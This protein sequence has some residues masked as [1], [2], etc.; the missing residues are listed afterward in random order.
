MPQIS[1]VLRTVRQSFNENIGVW[2]DV[3]NAVFD[4]IEEGMEGE[5]HIVTTGG[6]KQLSI[7]A[8]GAEDEAR[9]AVVRVTGAL[10]TNVTVEAPAAD[11]KYFV[12]NDTTGAFS[13]SIRSGVSGAPLAV[14]QGHAMMVRC[15]A[16]GRAVA[17]SPA[18]NITSGLVKLPDGSITQAAIDPA[19]IGTISTAQLTA[20][21]AQGA[22][23]TALTTATAAQTTASAALPRVGG[24]LTGDLDLSNHRVTSLLAPSAGTDAANKSYV[25]SVAAGGGLPI[26]GGAMT[27]QIDMTV[28]KIV[29]VA[30][31]TA[32]GDAVPLGQSF[33]VVGGAHATGLVPDPG[34]VVGNQRVLLDNGIWGFPLVPATAPPASPFVGQ[35]WKN[36]SA[37]AVS[38]VS[39]GAVAIW[40]GAA[41]YQTK[42]GSRNFSTSATAL[43]GGGAY[44]SPVAS[45]AANGMVGIDMNTSSPRLRVLETGRFLVQWS[46]PTLSITTATSP[47]NGNFTLQVQHQDASFTLIDTDVDDNQFYGTVAGSYSSAASLVSI[48]DATAGHF[49]EFKA[50]VFS[51]GTFTSGNCAAGLGAITRIY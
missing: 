26:G 27:G 36:T 49:I 45:L 28:H 41:W 7:S 31:A 23:N 15:I 47:G 18:V 30:T 46:I 43:A 5:V 20:T 19:V 4:R 51:N 2:G 39:P 37:A 38:N 11:K 12:I 3:A 44:A 10:I 42:F 6:L 21:A 32:L 14:A 13:V 35:M 16:D 17:M 29:N 33:G 40:D 50:R 22:A 1:P 34:A 24:I 48:F 8:T 9:K 25:D